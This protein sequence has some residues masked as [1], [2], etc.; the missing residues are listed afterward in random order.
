MAFLLPL[1]FN[2]L[3][4]DDPFEPGKVLLFQLIVLGMVGVA[5]WPGVGKPPWWRGN[6]LAVPVVV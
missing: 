1:F 5:F 3:A 4:L 6:P 2:P